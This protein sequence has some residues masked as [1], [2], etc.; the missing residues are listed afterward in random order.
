MD[1]K[2]LGYVS[3][4][5]FRLFPVNTIPPTLHIVFILILILSEG[6][7]GEDCETLNNVMFCGI[8][9]KTGQKN[10]YK[11]P[12]YSCFKGLS[13]LRVR[14]PQKTSAEII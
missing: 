4:R 6:Q 11:L 13:S 10:T 7:A 14:L 3:V 1:R 2:T 5:V 9:G 8:S 12:F